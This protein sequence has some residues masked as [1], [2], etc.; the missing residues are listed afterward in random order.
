MAVVKCKCGNPHFARVNVN[1]FKDNAASLHM[2][3]REVEPDHDIRLYQCINSK[4]NKYMMP[5]INYYTSTEDDKELYAIIQGALEGNIIE[6]SPKHKP[7]KIHAG[8]AAFIGGENDPESDG[9]FI[10]VQ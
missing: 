7:K 8:T 9:K 10:P 3:M 6:P 5:P 1:Q 4:C 2:S